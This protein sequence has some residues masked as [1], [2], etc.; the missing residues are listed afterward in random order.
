MN[1]ET[2]LR[3][4]AILAFK[5]K[6]DRPKP[7]KKVEKVDPDEIKSRPDSPVPIPSKIAKTDEAGDKPVEDTKKQIPGSNIL[8]N[9]LFNQS[10]NH[11]SHHKQHADHD[12][13]GGQR[14]ADTVAIR[15]HSRTPN[16]F[17]EDLRKR[18]DRSM[19]YEGGDDDVL[20][21]SEDVYGEEDFD[22]SDS[23]DL[24]SHFSSS[25]DGK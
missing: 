14:V 1:Y 2:S 12:H 11:A 24:E 22:Q 5:G 8:L 6:K 10:H 17:Q 15:Q 20:I 21:E 18:K 19:N 3:Y 23:E 4:I 7:R 9:N 25:D 16:P 13:E